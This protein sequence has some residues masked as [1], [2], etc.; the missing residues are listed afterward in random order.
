MY[1]L[2]ALW[3]ALVD[4]L[5]SFIGLFNVPAMFRRR[6]ARK[7]IA[8]Q[9]YAPHLA[10]CFASIIERLQHEYPDIEIHFII[11]FHPQLPLRSA[12]ILRDFVHHRLGIAQSNIHSYWQTL[13]SRYDIVVCT[14]V[15][16]KFPLRRSNRILLKHGAGVAD[17]ILKP[18][19]LRR[20]IFDFDLVLVSGDADYEVLR[21]RC[22]ESFIRNKVFAAGLPYLDRLQTCEESRHAYLRRLGLSP[23]KR[24]ALVAPSWRGLETIQDSDP[25]YLH[26]IVKVLRDLDWQVIMKLHACSFNPAMVGGRDWKTAINDYVRNGIRYDPDIDDIP[27]LLHSDLLITDI[28]SRAFNFLLLDKPVIAVLPENMF[29]DGLDRERVKLMVQAVFAARSPAEVKTIVRDGIPM[30]DPNLSEG[31]FLVSRIFANPGRATGVVV[32]H[33]LNAIN[34]GPKRDQGVC[35]D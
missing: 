35:A 1:K 33:L 22:P 23:D 27:A 24:I 2:I 29:T 14:D 32:G 34:G 31:R 25:N 10:Q 4:L 21:R 28:S 6:P 26:E 15:Y 19:F 18:S 30:Y 20:T 11:L 9:A 13:F 8:F 12:T 5:L 7:T 16:A 17:R 3:R